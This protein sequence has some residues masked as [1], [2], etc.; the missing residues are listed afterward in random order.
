MMANIVALYMDRLAW[1]TIHRALE[2]ERWFLTYLRRTD[3]P[4]ARKHTWWG[5]AEF[6]PGDFAW[7]RPAVP[8]PEPELE[9]PLPRV[10]IYTLN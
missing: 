5:R 9:P 2:R 3:H 4:C 1:E 6:M 7:V 8:E 10:V